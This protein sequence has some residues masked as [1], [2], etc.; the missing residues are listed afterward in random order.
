ML[1]LVLWNINFSFLKEQCTMLL[2]CRAHKTATQT[3]LRRK[4]ERR[5]KKNENLYA[6]KLCSRFLWCVKITVI[7]K[8]IVSGWNSSKMYLLSDYFQLQSLWSERLFFSFWLHLAD[9]LTKLHRFDTVAS[10]VERQS[11]CWPFEI[12][13][14]PFPFRHLPLLRHTSKRSLITGWAM[15]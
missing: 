11:H 2:Y 4:K 9:F 8:L 1:W 10:W 15:K 13:F 3:E 12:S 14:N 5:E 7:N 6:S